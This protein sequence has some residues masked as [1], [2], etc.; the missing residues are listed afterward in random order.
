MQ[1]DRRRA[2]PERR[3]LHDKRRRHGEGRPHRGP[4]HDF[5]P[6]FSPS[7]DE[8]VFSRV[9]FDRGSESSELVVVG[10]DGANKTQITDT[11]RAFEYEVDWQ[12]SCCRCP[13]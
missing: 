10:S 8:I 1:V 4:G 6:A 9:T 2:R 5:L 12:R 7:G 3:G 13:N 11:P